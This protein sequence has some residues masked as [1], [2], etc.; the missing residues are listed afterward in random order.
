MRITTGGVSDQGGGYI[1]YQ[2]VD[3]LSVID[4]STLD[5]IA[6]QLGIEY[7][8][9]TADTA[10]TLP[11]APS[12]TTDYAESGEV[13]NITELYWI[14]A[15]LILAILGVELARATMLI[16]RLRRLRAPRQLRSE[17]GG[18]S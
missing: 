10:P 3:A 12:T 13:G 15:L 18:A 1:Q 8:H 17:Q 7:A 5:T 11:E 16:A 9:R 14:A 2:G 4:E 6:G